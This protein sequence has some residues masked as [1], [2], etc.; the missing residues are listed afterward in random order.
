MYGAEIQLQAFRS[1]KWQLKET[2]AENVQRQKQK[3][4]VKKVIQKF[5][6]I[7][8]AKGC[9]LAKK[10]KVTDKKKVTNKHKKQAKTSTPKPETPNDFKNEYNEWDEAHEQQ[11]DL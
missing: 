1:L 11:E 9:S 5:G 7:T 4:N 3:A 2:K 10:R 8:V 6:V